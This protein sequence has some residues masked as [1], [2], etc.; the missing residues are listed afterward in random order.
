[1]NHRRGY[2]LLELMAT[3][4]ILAIVAGTAFSVLRLDSLGNYGAKTVARTLAA[5]LEFARYQA[6]SSGDDHF[7]SLTGS[8]NITQYTLYRDTGVSTSAV[9]AARKI[10]DQVTVTISPAASQTPSFTFEGQADSSFT[11]TVAGLSRTFQVVVIAATGR[12]QVTEL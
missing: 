1:M 3:V 12:A 6:I 9:D 11:F 2:S 10:P 7:L 4:V 5:D 8:P